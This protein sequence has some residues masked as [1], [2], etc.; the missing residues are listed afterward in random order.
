LSD[1]DR[2]RE[3]TA[4]RKKDTKIKL[5]VPSCPLWLPTFSACLRVRHHLNLSHA[6]PA[7]ETTVVGPVLARAAAQVDA[8]PAV[9]AALTADALPQAAYIDAPAA[10]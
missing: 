9:V 5:R 4:K 8:P 7:A 10:D 3:P 1:A 6:I 2:S